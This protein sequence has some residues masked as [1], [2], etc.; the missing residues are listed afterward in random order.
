M[1]LL[2]IL[3]IS[4]DSERNGK[5]DIYNASLNPRKGFGDILLHQLPFLRPNAQNK[6]NDVAQLHIVGIRVEF[7]NL[8]NGNIK[9]FRTHFLQ[10]LTCIVAEVPF[11]ALLNVIDIHFQHD[12]AVMEVPAENFRTIMDFGF[13]LNIVNQNVLNEESLISL[14]NLPVGDDGL[15][16]QNNVRGCIF[17]RNLKARILFLHQ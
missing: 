6:N 4:A 14:R 12:S 2:Y 3:V 7:Q 16:P 17:Q 8:P 9:D 5:G 13:T 15:L 10:H 1:N 11:E